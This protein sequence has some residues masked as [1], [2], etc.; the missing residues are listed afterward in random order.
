MNFIHKRYNIV[1][2]I[3]VVMFVLV[4][5]SSIIYQSTFLIPILS[6]V[7]IIG[8]LFGIQSHKIRLISLMHRKLSLCIAHETATKA[9]TQRVSDSEIIIAEKFIKKYFWTIDGISFLIPENGGLFIKTKNYNFHLLTMPEG[10]MD[11][12]IEMDCN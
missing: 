11:E 12:I 1:F 8:L 5:T 10:K 7:V 3:C 6:A 9:K 2:W 4:T